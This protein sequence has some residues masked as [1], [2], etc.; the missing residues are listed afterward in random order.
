M[1]PRRFLFLNAIATAL[2]LAAAP[3]LPAQSPPAVRCD[4]LVGFNGTVREG[5]F[6]PVVLSVENPGARL[7]AEIAVRVTWGSAQQ[8]VFPG[9][10]ITQ[11]AVLDAGSTRRFPFLIPVPRN[12]RTLRATVTSSGSELGGIE[13]EL[14]QL[15]TTSRIIAGI[16]SELSLDALSA[17]GS[18]GSVRV[19][20]PRIDDLPQSWAG[21]DGVDA[22][23]VHDTSFQQL[24]SDQVA[25]LEGWV[26]TGGV[27]VFTGGA[28]ALQHEPAGFGRLLPVEITGLTARAGIAAVPVGGGTVRRVPGQVEVAESRLTRGRVVAGD[29]ALPL[30]V[31]RRLGRGSI[32]FL[33]FDPTTAAF[34]SWGGALALWRTLLDADRLPTMGAASRPAMED[35]W[36]AGLFA[37]S[38]VSFPPVPALLAFIAADVALLAPLLVGRR[39]M[40]ARVRL[41]LLVG[42]SIVA[43]LAG[44][45]VFNRTLFRP[46]LQVID[47]ARVE[48]RS[49][50]G[51][52]IVME[53]FGFF[54]ASAQPVEARLGSPD[55]VLES[56]GF[57]ARPDLPPFESPLVLAHAGA[58]VLVRGIDL[59]R[60]GARL[61]VAQ[62]VVP[63][64]VIARVQKSGSSFEAFVSNGNRKP[65]LGCF[66]LVAGRVYPFGDVGAGASVQRTFSFADALGSAVDGAQMPRDTVAGAYPDAD[67]RRAALLKAEAV[68][69]GPGAGPARLVGW[70]DGPALPLTFAGA[71]PLGARPG[72]ALVSVEAE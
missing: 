13:V 37:A 49:G 55:A 32:W 23:I 66:I 3:F 18:A 64:A 42:V 44:W 59:E 48:A 17:L 30:V 67:G 46:G 69:D 63:F 12:V 50:E 34:G 47:A 25:A 65:L 38:P 53:K 24:R 51:L 57:Q 54:A 72:L 45:I 22:V 2:L 27:L 5:R 8:G 26:A 70:T 71:Q 58:R 41:A 35:P 20:Y 61:L 29:G 16:S 10:T 21:Y 56:A 68:I 36:I 11:E 31:Q 60:L 7:K 1:G 15:T 40:K 28:A 62:D 52:A 6:A 19:V 39:R 9:R 14:R 33:A 4:V 43:V